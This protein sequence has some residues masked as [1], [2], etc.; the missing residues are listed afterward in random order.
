MRLFDVFTWI[1]TT[2]CRLGFREI[3]LSP[4]SESGSCALASRFIAIQ[5]YKNVGFLNFRLT[6]KSGVYNFLNHHFPF[7]PYTFYFSPACP[8]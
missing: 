2:V 4:S 6:A 1:R 7:P 5:L 3:K 8:E